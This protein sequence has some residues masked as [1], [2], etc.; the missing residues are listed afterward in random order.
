MNIDNLNYSISQVAEIVEVAQSTLRYWET[1]IAVFDPHK[2]DGGSRRYRK[3]DIE[4]ILKIKDL[5]HT[6]GLTIKGANLLLSNNSKATNATTSTFSNNNL[7]NNELIS[8]RD[9]LKKIKNILDH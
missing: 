6:Q 8:I 4:L 3:K 9:E 5:L 2:T 1:V 7:S